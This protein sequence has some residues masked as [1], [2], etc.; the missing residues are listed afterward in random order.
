MDPGGFC[1]LIATKSFNMIQLTPFHF[2]LFE[3]ASPNNVARCLEDRDED[4]GQQTVTVHIPE[5]SGLDVETLKDLT[6]RS[7]KGEL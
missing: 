3:E 2:H 1:V 7:G 6:E 4:I 5:K